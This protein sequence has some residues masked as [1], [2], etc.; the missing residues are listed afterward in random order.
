LFS[1]HRLLVLTDVGLAND[2]RD[3]LQKMG[4]VG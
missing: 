1:C 4:A 2:L 3:Y